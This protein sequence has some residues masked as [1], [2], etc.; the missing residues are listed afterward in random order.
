M[1]YMWFTGIFIKDF[2]GMTQLQVL[3]KLNKLVL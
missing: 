3:L 1:I 2:I